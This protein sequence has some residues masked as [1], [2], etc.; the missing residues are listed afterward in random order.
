MLQVL[1]SIRVSAPKY[2]FGVSTKIVTPPSPC[3]GHVPANQTAPSSAS[4]AEPAENRIVP[5]DPVA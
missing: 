4:L 3:G 5:P 2:R 1:S